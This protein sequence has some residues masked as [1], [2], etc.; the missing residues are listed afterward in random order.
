MFMFCSVMNTFNPAFEPDLD[1][2]AARRLAVARRITEMALAVAEAVQ[3]LALARLEAEI[4]AV[5]RA[6]D[7]EAAEAAAPK[8]RGDDPVARSDRALRMVRLSL[9]L[10]ARLEADEPARR[11][12]VR[13]D[14]AAARQ[15][16][17]EAKH[18]AIQAITTAEAEF[19]ADRE[20]MV[21]DVLTATLQTSGLGGQAV[22]DRRERLAER[23]NETAAEWEYDYTERAVG[24]VIAKLAEDLDITVDWS[25]WTDTAWAMEEAAANA[26][27]SPY[28]AGGA[29]WVQ[30][31]DAGAND[32][33][34]D[35]VRQPVPADGSSP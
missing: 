16:A 22:R 31:A 2:R 21:V 5:G 33:P 19:L 8:G 7:G 29:A 34:D 9:A 17:A 4:A 26:E 18:R 11:A 32:P 24:A 12:G 10:E 30:A 13:A 23:L 14:E 3:R 27:G 28:A 20:D 1:A 6:D 25:L 35:G 15:A